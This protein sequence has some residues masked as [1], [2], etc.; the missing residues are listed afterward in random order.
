M[1]AIGVHDGG[2]ANGCD[3]RDTDTR[4]LSRSVSQSVSKSS[5]EVG[6]KSLEARRNWSRAMIRCVAGAN[7]GTPAYKSSASDSHRL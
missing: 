1:S 6:L 2:E 5:D 3:G 4:D 7:N